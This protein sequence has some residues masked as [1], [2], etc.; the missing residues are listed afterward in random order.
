MKISTKTKTCA[1][2]A[3]G[4]IFHL[5]AAAGDKIYSGGEEVAENVISEPSDLELS[6]IL[7]IW[8]AGIEGTVGF[9]P[10][11][12]TGIDVGIDDILPTIDMIF[13]STVEVR[14]GK[15]GFTLDGMY[16]K[17][18]VDGE[19]PGPLLNDISVTMRQ[20]LVDGLITYR[21]FESEEA[22]LELLAGARYNYQDSEVTFTRFD[23][24]PGALSVTNSWVD[25]FFGIQ[26]RYQ[27]ADKWYVSA[28]ADYGGF[29]VSSE[30][31]YNLFGVVGYQIK[32]GT[33]MELG[34]RYLA[35]DYT[36][37]GFVYDVATKGAFIGFRMDF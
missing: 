32:P 24:T 2:L 31:T 20:V 15:L 17:L 33:S 12:T 34:Y 5:P 21:V 37:G 14:K 29:G 28:R 27:L 4:L 22:W 36:Q 10:D 7:P 23:T 18:S 30:S 3:L 19:T 8:L 6:L 13:A 11:V 16:M 35:T 26:G 1:F 9:T 25:P